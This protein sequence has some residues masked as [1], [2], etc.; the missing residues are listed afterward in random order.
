MDR[1]WIR[2]VCWCV[3][4]L[5]LT[6]PAFAYEV[7]EVRDG[8]TMTGIVTLLGPVPQPKAYNLVTFPDPEYCGRISNGDGWR[9]LRDFTVDGASRLKDVIVVLEG[10]SAG[11]PFSVSIPRVEARDC[12]FLPFATVVRDGHGVE[13]V[14]M[15]PVMHDIQAYETS[16]SHG[17]RV[18]FNSPLPFN[19]KHKR[20]DMHAMHNHLPGRS[21]VQQFAMSKGRKTFVM[22]C[23][24]HAYM[25]SW[26]L[27]VDNPYY[28]ITNHEGQFVIDRIPPGDY[29]LTVWHPSI[30]QPLEQAVT[31]RVN[32]TSSVNF[33]L[34]A[35][36]GRRTSLTVQR[37]PR[38]GPEAL[39]RPLT[40]Q[41]L[42]ERQ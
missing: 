27:T 6:A 38:F 28:A 37:P 25:E 3:L 12:Q 15:D 1:Q 23:G 42:V 31:I 33:E 35:P 40:I 14:N 20:G 10:V 5:L 32:E 13:I 30:K 17:T 29:R 26:A 16:R 2:G 9:L 39:G 41:P 24:F 22:Q 11:K 19:H 36:V 8:G 34:Q 4:T 18:L 21:M 7:I